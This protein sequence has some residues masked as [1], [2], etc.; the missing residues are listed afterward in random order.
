MN[1]TFVGPN[2]SKQIVRKVTNKKVYQEP[3]I[4]F[5]INNLGDKDGEGNKSGQ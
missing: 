3:K 2:N 5:N 4:L 1:F